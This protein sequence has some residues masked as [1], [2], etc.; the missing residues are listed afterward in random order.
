VRREGCSP[1]KVLASFTPNNNNNYNPSAFNISNNTHW[2]QP[3]HDRD[4]ELG[5]VPSVPSPRPGVEMGKGVELGKERRFKL[6]ATLWALESIGLG[7]WLQ[8]FHG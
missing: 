7:M 3:G 1:G 8:T 4:I 6:S 2:Q 5:S